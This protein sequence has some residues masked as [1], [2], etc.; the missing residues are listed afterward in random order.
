[1]R[2]NGLIAEANSM[3][4]AAQPRALRPGNTRDAAQPMAKTAATVT[5]ALKPRPNMSAYQA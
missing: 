5:T 2:I 1:M 3:V 4:L